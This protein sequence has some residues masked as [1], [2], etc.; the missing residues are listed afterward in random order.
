M[1]DDGFAQLRMSGR[2]LFL[3]FFP[4]ELLI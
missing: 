3:P 1:G 4:A 2:G